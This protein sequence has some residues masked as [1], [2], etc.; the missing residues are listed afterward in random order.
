MVAA[1]FLPYDFP[2]T[3]IPRPGLRLYKKEESSW[4]P[5]QH[6]F[7]SLFSFTGSFISPF[8]RPLSL[9]GVSKKA[10]FAPNEGTHK[11]AALPP[12]SRKMERL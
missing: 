11:R 4:F 2:H 5:S 8:G 9:S 6:K 3:E 1:S 12:T 10:N 7:P